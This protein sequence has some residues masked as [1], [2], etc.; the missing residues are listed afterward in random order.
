MGMEKLVK[1]VLKAFRFYVFFI[2]VVFYFCFLTYSS[3][4]I[5]SEVSFGKGGYLEM[6]AER[7]SKIFRNSKVLGAKETEID[8]LYAIFLLGK[9]DEIKVV[10]FYPEKGLL[11]L[12][13]IWTINGTS[14]TGEQIL[15]FERGLKSF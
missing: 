14:L 8:G 10:Y 1:K 2:C 3:Y 7:F 4:G 11:F 12:G 9:G 13:E 15:E 6:V 5:E